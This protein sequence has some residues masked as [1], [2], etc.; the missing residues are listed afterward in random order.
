MAFL[1]LE[2]W[3]F[4][5][6]M[7]P[8]LFWVSKASDRESC[9]CCLLQ[10]KKKNKKKTGY[11]NKLHNQTYKNRSLSQLYLFLVCFLH[12]FIEMLI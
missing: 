6:F 9:E 3:K 11:Y 10:V 2:L 8:V 7:V 4:V 12:E 5:F 1:R